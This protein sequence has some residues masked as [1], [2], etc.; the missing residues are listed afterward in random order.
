MKQVFYSHGKLLLTAE[1]LV[2]DN[3]KALALP[4]RKGQSMT[5]KTSDDSYIH[6]KSFDV[7]NTCWFEYSFKVSHIESLLKSTQNK[8]EQTLLQLLSIAKQLN[9][10]FLS[11]PQGYFIHT[12]LEFERTWGLGSSSTLINNIASW[13]SIDPYKLL[14]K[15]FGGSGY[16]IACA[17]HE[18]PILYQKNNE[19]PK[20]TPTLFE[21]A[22][23]D[24]IFF[25]HLNQ[26]QDSKDSIKHY[27]ALQ[28]EEILHAISRVNQLTTEILNCKTLDK[29]ETLLIEHENLISS[30]IQTA[31]VQSRL[32]ADYTSG[33]VKSLGGWGGD[34]ILVTTKNYN[35][36]YFIQKG[37]KTILSFDEM[38]LSVKK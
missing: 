18:T 6:W 34:F 8:F 5:V 23:K 2:L 24:H 35:L 36:D 19:N 12:Y 7:H 15:G 26:K 27:R 13:A 32:F 29:F 21:P 9:P 22:F 4:T 25:I 33:V 38:L 16:D 28:K 31:T 1:Y 30:V 11:S 10:E 20:V 37:Y 3:A 14:F 17:S